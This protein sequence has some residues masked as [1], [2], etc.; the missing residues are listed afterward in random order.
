MITTRLNYLSTMVPAMVRKI[1]KV[2]DKK[3]ACEQVN[4]EMDTHLAELY[5]NDQK[6]L[7]I[8]R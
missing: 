2:K 7:I 3:A 4:R 6:D 5:K 1:R 8:Q